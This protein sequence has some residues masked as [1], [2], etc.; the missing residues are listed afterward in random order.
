[1]T[2]NDISK[3][4]VMSGANAQNA[5]GSTS[6]QHWWPNQLNLKILSQNSDLCDPMNGDFDYAEEFKTVDLDELKKDIEE[7][8]TT[9]QDW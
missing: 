2:D 3:C 9:S 5:G 4:P 1:M 7:L 6:N 8:M